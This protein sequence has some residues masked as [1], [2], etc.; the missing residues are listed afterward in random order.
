MTEENLD[1]YS[2]D[3]HSRQPRPKSSGGLRRMAITL[4]VL[5]FAWMLFA[6]I[7]PR[8][9]LPMTEQANKPQPVRP[10]AP[11]P[12]HF[13]GGPLQIRMEALEKELQ[14]LRA[15]QV[16]DPQE[17]ERTIARL[18]QAVKTLQ[19][20]PVGKLEEL[21]NQQQQTI[22]SLEEKLQRMERDTGSH[23]AGMTALTQMR[24]A[25]VRGEPF[26]YEIKRLKQMTRLRPEVDDMLVPLGSLAANGVATQ[27]QLEETFEKTVPYALSPDTQP[28]SLMAN[29]KS[30]VSIRKTGTPVGSDDDAII[31]RAETALKE[32]RV[33]ASIN[34]LKELSPGAATAFADWKTAAQ[35][36]ILSR[37]VLDALEIAL[38]R[39]DAPA[40]TD[41]TNASADKEAPPARKKHKRRRI[42]RERATQPDGVIH[43]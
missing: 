35:Q 30:L 27:A 29:L 5:F 19:D 34:I 32:N 14:E 4:L 9:T 23:L 25:I 33:Q 38:V 13:D 41:D 11:P 22:A 8:L 7:A 37:E 26:T 43:D 2:N 21:I 16:D 1:S 15:H 3:E 10:D 12:P 28:D 6:Q 18:E 39:K 17:T 42:P 36:H 31:A 24:E 40:S 20:Q